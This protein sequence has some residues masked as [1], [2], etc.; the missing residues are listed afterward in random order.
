MTIIDNAIFTKSSKYYR[1]GD[2]Y[3][4]IAHPKSTQTGDVYG[5]SEQVN[6]NNTLDTLIVTTVVRTTDWV[7]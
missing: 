2:L 3:P 7:D 1:I 5:P 6:S 4:N